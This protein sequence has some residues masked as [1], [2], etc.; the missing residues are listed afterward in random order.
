MGNRSVN[1]LAE[2]DQSGR[3]SKPNHTLLGYW[4]LPDD[5]ESAL[6]SVSN[7]IMDSSNTDSVSDEIERYIYR[8]A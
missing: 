2:A 7:L 4:T 8:E 3:Q 5:P 6:V 1:R